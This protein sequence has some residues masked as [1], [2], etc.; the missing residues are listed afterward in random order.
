MFP[1]LEVRFCETFFVI[2][3]CGFGVGLTAEEVSHES[4]TGQVVTLA[5]W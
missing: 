3:V 2:F 4:K 1:V 5:D